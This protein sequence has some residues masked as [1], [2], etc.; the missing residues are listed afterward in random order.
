LTDEELNEIEA[1]YGFVPEH[2]VPVIPCAATLETL[3]LWELVNGQFVFAG[4]DGRPIALDTGS[5]S[6]TLRNVGLDAECIE[7]EIL[8][9][10]V[11]FK[12]IYAAGEDKK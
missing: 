4:M 7:R 2:L 9:M 11:I 6:T 10:Q 5:I 12:H 1:E 3:R 8:K